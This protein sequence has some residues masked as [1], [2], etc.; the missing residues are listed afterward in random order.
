MDNMTQ[1]WIRACKSK[2]PMKRLESLV[3]RYYGTNVDTVDGLVEDLICHNLVEVCE[4][5]LPIKPSTIIKE[6][7]SLDSFR[8]P[9]MTDNGKFLKVHLDHIR[10]HKVK[11]LEGLRTPLRFKNKYGF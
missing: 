9:D 8:Y 1:L 4:Y 5:F 2:D 7:N 3:R 11:N 10:Q 6:F